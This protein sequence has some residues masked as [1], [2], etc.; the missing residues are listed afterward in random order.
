MQ[1]FWLHAFVNP[2]QYP[3]DYGWCIEATDWLT[4]NQ[5]SLA[6]AV[7]EEGQ[8]EDA[9]TVEFDPDAQEEDYD[10][11][12]LID[13]L[14]DCNEAIFDVVDEDGNHVAQYSVAIWNSNANYTVSGGSNEDTVTTVN[15]T[16][17][18]RVINVIKF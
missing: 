1:N 8:T 4:W 16:F 3:E 6:D 5:I 13:S 2:G 18:H 12:A 17:K 7:L 14:A 10:L 11:D 9:L 15:W